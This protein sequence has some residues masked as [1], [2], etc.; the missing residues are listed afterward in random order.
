[1]ITAPRQC[2]TSTVL[3]LGDTST[4]I[5]VVLLMLHPAVEPELNIFRPEYNQTLRGPRTLLLTAFIGSEWV[6]HLPSP[7]SDLVDHNCRL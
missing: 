5:I 7:R 1:M 4:L 3:T 2:A 6:R